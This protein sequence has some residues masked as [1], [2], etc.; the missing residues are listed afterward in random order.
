[1]TQDSDPV[2]DKFVDSLAHPGGNITGLTN[3]SLE[4]TGKRLELLRDSVAGLSHVMV[5][6][7]SANRANAQVLKDTQ[8]AAQALRLKLEYHDMQRAEDAESA[9]K[10]AAKAGARA[11]LVLQNPVARIYGDRVVQ[12][13]VKYRLPAMYNRSDF[14][15]GGGLMFYGADGVHLH[16]RAA[17]YVDKI[18]K[19]AKPADLPVEQPTKF[20][21]VINLKAAKQIGLTVPPNVLARA[22]RVIKESA[23]IKPAWSSG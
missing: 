14:V 4:V 13:A 2:G 21:L 22:D 16:R 10:A 15:E 18:L 7:N 5:L 12:L 1:M 8:N 9:F 6:G 3:V 20:E 19:G 17:T 11:L 23:G